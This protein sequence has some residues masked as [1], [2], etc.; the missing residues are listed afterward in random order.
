MQDLKNNKLFW[1]L[2]V[3][4]IFNIGA[5]VLGKV[6]IDRAADRVIKKLQKEYSPS[7][8]GPGFD[9]DKVSPD[10][11]KSQKKYF[12]MRKRIATKSFQGEH[13]FLEGNNLENAVESA[14][15]WRTE[16]EKERGVTK[17]D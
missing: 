9:P 17:F 14:D 1:V 11:F 7:P 4:T 5:F 15:K 2:V 10:A 3:V 12:E 6:I 16:W 8:Y 13:A